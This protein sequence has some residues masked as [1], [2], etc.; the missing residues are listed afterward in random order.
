MYNES[1]QELM[2]FKKAA[3]TDISEFEIQKDEKYYDFFTDPSR[4]QP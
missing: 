2:A 4:L 1:Y 3:K